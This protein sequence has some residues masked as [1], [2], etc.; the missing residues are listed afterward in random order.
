MILRR[1]GTALHSV[2]T[3]FDSKALNEVGFR[4]DRELS[5]AAEEFEETY[6]LVE[7]HEISAETEGDV[8]D[9]TQ[10]RLL[11]EMEAQLRTL[12]E[13][14]GEGEVLVVENEQGVDYPKT[15]DIRKNVI[16]EGENRLHFTAVVE[17]PLRVGVYRKGG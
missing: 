17:P 1:Y 7:S 14:L 2:D 8:Q 10:Q 4:R 6:E 3:D 5:I 16:V 11:D 12:E 9:E 15:K 13:K